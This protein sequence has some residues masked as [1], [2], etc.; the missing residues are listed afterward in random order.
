MTPTSNSTPAERPSA[1]KE[2]L[3]L[4]GI[5]KESTRRPGT[6]VVVET[7]DVGHKYGLR[8]PKCGH[9]F[10]IQ[11]MEAGARRACCP[12]CQTPVIYVAVSTEPDRQQPVAQQSSPTVVAAEG[13]NHLMGA[14]AHGRWIFRKIVSLRLGA[15]YIGRTDHRNPSDIEFD[16]GN[17]SA[18]SVRIDVS[19]MDR[20]GYAFKFTVLRATNPVYVNGTQYSTGESVYLNFGDKLQLG[21][22]KLEFTEAKKK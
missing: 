1:G 7:G 4:L 15:N 12:H 17:M 11:P 13:S 6:Y 21:S 22:T 16:D 14:I 20:G 18:R 8:C 19:L 9:A 10:A 2:R 5:A 3:K